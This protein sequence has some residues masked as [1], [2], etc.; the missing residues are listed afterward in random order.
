MILETVPENESPLFRYSSLPLRGLVQPVA[1]ADLAH[2]AESQDRDKQVHAKTL[3]RFFSEGLGK[4]LDLVL[5]DLAT[6]LENSWYRVQGFRFVLLV[7]GCRF[8]EGPERIN[9]SRDP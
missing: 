3:G 8:N 5:S 6:R 9:I 1:R 4:T 7:G 2:R